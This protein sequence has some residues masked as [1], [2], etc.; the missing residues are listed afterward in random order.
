MKHI[1]GL[2]TLISLDNNMPMKPLEQIEFPEGYGIDW[3]KLDDKASTLNL[4]EA[5]IFCNGEQS[6][7]AYITKK[8]GLED[9]DSVLNGIFDGPLGKHFWA[10]AGEVQNEQLNLIGEQESDDIPSSALKIRCSCLDLHPWKSMYR[11]LY[12][13]AWFCKSCAEEHF[14]KTVEEYQRESDLEV[15]LSATPPTEGAAE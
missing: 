12:C 8:K 2:V 14:G 9:L 6:E 10:P 13:S 5:E 11:C 3:K 15:L 1:L 7:A 4:K